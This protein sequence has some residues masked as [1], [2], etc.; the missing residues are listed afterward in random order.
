MSTGTGTVLFIVDQLDKWGLSRTGPNSKSHPA[1]MELGATV[2]GSA[3]NVNR[4]NCYRLRV[5]TTLFGE[6]H[7][8]PCDMR[9]DLRLPGDTLLQGSAILPADAA[10]EC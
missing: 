10:M 5:V 3:A 1:R 7:R 2:F 6:A 4:T 8:F 9:R